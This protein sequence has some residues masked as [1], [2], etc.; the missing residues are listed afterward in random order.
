LETLSVREVGDLPE[1]YRAVHALNRLGFGPR[2]GDVAQLNAGGIERYIHEQLHPESLPIPESL[3]SQVASYR[4]LHM[5][6][7]ELFREFQ[8]PVMQARRENRGADPATL[9]TALKN[10]RVRARIVMREAVEARLVRAIE[11]PRQLQEV[12]TAFWFNHFNVFAAKGLDAI[13][14]GSFEETAIRP[15]TL[16]KF[17][18]LL[19]AT[20]KH[21]AMLFYLD[22]WQNSAPHGAGSKG[23]FEGINENYARELM[24]LHT[25]G[26]NGGYTQQDVIAL[27]HI[28]TGWGLPKGRGQQSGQGVQ[29]PTRA[30]FAPFPRLQRPRWFNPDRRMAADPSGF[31]FDANRHDFGPKMFLGHRIAGSGIQEG[32]DALDI[33]ARHSATAQHLS[34]QLAQYFVA[35]DPPKPLVE[36]MALRY[37]QTDGDIRQ[38]LAAIFASPEFWDRRYYAAK[39][40]SP[41]EY[42]VSSVRAANVA[43]S[44]FRPLYGT[45]QLLGMPLYGCQTP[46]GYSNT[47]DAWLNPDAMMTRLSFATALGSGNL[48]LNRPAFEE[49]E[50]GQGASARPVVSRN[51][52]IGRVQINYQPEK[53]N[54]MPAPDATMLVQALGG[55]LSASTRAAIEAAPAPLHAALVLGSPEFMMR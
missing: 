33:L 14:T 9:K 45:M 54:R 48:P 51:G 2:A 23:K 1:E 36:R 53:P 38:V 43:V 37:L 17:R 28:L 8:L 16:G 21:P 47:R 41:Y 24:E 19:G 25:M 6:P 29:P 35:D 12:M 5:T 11:G 50:S 32:E 30:H 20:A 4:T 27:A 46:N 52:G 26:V 13:W 55:S 39:F 15:H 7:M 40:K 34:Y 42:V 18:A 22:N 10:E 3:V 44:N 31:Y 49:D